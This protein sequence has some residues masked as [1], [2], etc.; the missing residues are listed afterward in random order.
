[1]IQQ[2]LLSIC[3]NGI[4]SGMTVVHHGKDKALSNDEINQL[5]QFRLSE[6]MKQVPLDKYLTLNKNIYEN[7]A[8]A[9]S[10]KYVL[11]DI[12][13]TLSPDDKQINAKIATII[14]GLESNH[15]K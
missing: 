4:T 12:Y 13:E 5:C 10:H 1:P 6:F 9:Y 8:R 11:K 3:K 2:E 14:L 7:F 15:A